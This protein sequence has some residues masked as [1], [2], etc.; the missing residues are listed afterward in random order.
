MSLRKFL[1]L[2]LIIS[3]AL[4]TYYSSEV[5]ASLHTLENSVH[6]TH[7]LILVLIVASILQISGH[8]VRAYK[9]KLLLSPIKE[10]STRFQFRA[11]SIG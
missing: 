10:S 4:F 1:L 5:K 9:A 3:L 11:L 2:P 7:R 6:I 8:I